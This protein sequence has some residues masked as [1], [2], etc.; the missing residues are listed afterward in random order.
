MHPEIFSIG[1]FSVK[2]WGFALAISVILATIIA[3]KRSKRFGVNPDILYDLIFVV[4]VSAI[5]GSRIWYV[6]FHLDEFTG[7][8]FDVINPFH[9][10]G[11][12][13]IA[14][15]SMM[16]GVALVIIG[17]AIYA[18]IRKLDFYKV[19]DVIA[20]TFLLGAGI[21]RI[22]CFLNGCCYGR[23]TDGPLSIIFTGG[24][25]GCY[26]DQFLHAH[27]ETTMT[28]LIPTQLIASAA[29]FILFFVVLWMERWHYFD[30]YTSWLVFIFYSIDR[31]AVDQ[32]RTYEV[33]QIIGY[34]GP[35]ML[36]VN[37]I[38]L[39]G[40]LF[41]SAIMFVIGSSRARKKH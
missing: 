16:G 33:E 9:G 7:N 12:F 29:G 38:I 21:T 20:P 10:P 8:W 26:W 41:F 23:P 24:A 4:V 36:T 35:I 6:V 11:G 39:F 14:G 31:F 22:G 15:L 27:P 17:V 28:G 18:A 30:G 40:L 25:A 1:P 3:N 37:E 5:V 32:F 2:S 19:A 34:V 13:G